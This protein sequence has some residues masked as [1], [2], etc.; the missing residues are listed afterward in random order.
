MFPRLCRGPDPD[1]LT[2]SERCVAELA[3]AG[4][5]NRDIAQALFITTNTVETHLIETYRKLRIN[6][7]ANLTSASLNPPT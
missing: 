2:P 6:S 3:A 1:P 4:R 5:S 7:Q